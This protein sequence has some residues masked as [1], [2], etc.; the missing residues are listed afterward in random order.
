M[1]DAS[2]VRD[3]KRAEAAY[4]KERKEVEKHSFSVSL[5]GTKED[6]GKQLAEQVKDSAL[7]SAIKALVAAAPGNAVSVAGTMESSE[8]GK[9]GKITVN[10]IFKTIPDEVLKANADAR[11]AEEKERRKHA[12]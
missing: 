8:D 11:A 1:S 5:S 4:Q 10:G 12:K 3:E 9:T 2:V 6:A 7:A